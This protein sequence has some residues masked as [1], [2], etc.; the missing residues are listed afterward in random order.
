MKEDYRY[1]ELL[2]IKARAAVYTL[3][4]TEPKKAHN[5]SSMY[6]ITVKERI[7]KSRNKGIVSDGKKPP[8][9]NIWYPP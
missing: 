7:E 2:V 3:Y 4:F 1:N 9:H 5:F 8:R 6:I